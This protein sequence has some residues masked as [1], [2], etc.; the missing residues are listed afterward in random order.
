MKRLEE[1]RKT[2][3]PAQHQ[4]ASTEKPSTSSAHPDDITTRKNIQSQSSTKSAVSDNYDSEDDME[5]SLPVVKKRGIHDD[6]SDD[7]AKSPVQKNQRL[8]ADDIAASRKTGIP[9]PKLTQNPPGM[10]KLPEVPKSGTSQKTPKSQ[11][12]VGRADRRAD[13]ATEQSAS[14]GHSKPPLIRPP[15]KPP[16]KKAETK[17]KANANKNK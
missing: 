7:E 16:E 14:S 1:I 10:S 4:T 13:K 6:S 8:P 12:A 2:K 3:A 15:L 11:E 17:K 9:M 5:C